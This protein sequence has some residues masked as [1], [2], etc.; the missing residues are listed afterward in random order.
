MPTFTNVPASRFPSSVALV[1]RDDAGLDDISAPAWDALAGGQP[2][3]SHAFLQALEA[4]GCVSRPTGWT[5]SHLTAW[6]QGRLV[7]A[8]PLYEKSHSYGEYVFDWSWADAY[9]RHGRRYYPKLVCAVPFTPAPGPRVLATSTHVRDALLDAALLRVDERARP[10]HVSSLHV[11]FATEAEAAG[12]RARGLIVREGLQFHWENA[13]YRD[14]SD[15]LAAFNHDKRKK[16]KQERRRLAEAGVACTRRAGADIR[17]RDW[18]LFY[19]CYENTYHQHGSTPYLTLEFFLRLAETMPDS[20]LMVIGSRD[21][22]DIAAALDVFDATTLWGRYWGTTEYVPGLHFEVCYYQALEFCIE[23]GLQRFEGGAQG[24]HKLAR[25]LMPV[26]TYSAHA[27]G[28]PAFREAI[29]EFCAR[30]RRQ[31]ARTVDEL[32]SSAPF[33]RMEDEL[34]LAEP[35]ERDK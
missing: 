35:F 28:D 30:E 20:L 29:A 14:F 10:G 31:V 22:E 34:S 15:L 21:G 7:G 12:L 17:A 13:G 5:P 2:L 33:R 24:V 32:E 11:L 27:I 25:G 19:R 6:Q 23:R 18:Q 4:S 1:V 9:R 8:M 3:L 16:V 26:T